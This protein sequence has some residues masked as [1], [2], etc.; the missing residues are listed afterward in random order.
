MYFYNQIKAS[1]DEEL[2]NT[3]AKRAICE[4]TKYSFDLKDKIKTKKMACG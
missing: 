3:I 1:E 4:V 2:F